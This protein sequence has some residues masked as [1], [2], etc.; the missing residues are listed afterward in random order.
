MSL[1]PK[2]AAAAATLAMTA[3]SPALA[4]LSTGGVNITG[5]TNPTSIVSNGINL[6]LLVLGALVLGYWA[7]VGG[8]HLRGNPVE[9]RWIV[10]GVIGTIFIAGCAYIG[11]RLLSGGAGGIAL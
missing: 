2:R 4:Q 9:G 7:V 6:L 3:A 8:M 10:G 5:N 1:L 11:Q